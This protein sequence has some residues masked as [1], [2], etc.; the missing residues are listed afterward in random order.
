MTST[1]A[2]AWTLGFAAA[3]WV[4]VVRQ[5]SG[6]DM[7]S[8]TELGSFSF[9]PA[10]WATMMAAMM[11][12]GAVPAVSRVVRAQDRNLAAPLFAASY[13]AVWALFGLAVHALYRPHSTTVAGLLT[14]AA[15]LY[16]FTPLKRECRR[17]CR[18][19]CAQDSNSAP[20]ASAR[21]L[22]SW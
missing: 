6:M 14:I 5:M 10:V 21:P 18:A 13:L 9:F 1:R 4:L 16:E 2:A 3:C 12:P 17:R 11:L 15:G 20:T 19:K 8:S 7:G 22:A